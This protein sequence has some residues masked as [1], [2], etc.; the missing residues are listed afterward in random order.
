MD[1]RLRLLV[2]HSSRCPLPGVTAQSGTVIMITNGLPGSGFRPP[3]WAI[4]FGRP[5]GRALLLGVHGAAAAVLVFALSRVSDGLLSAGA[6]IFAILLVP[7]TAGVIL[8]TVLE[9]WLQ[10][11]RTSGTRGRPELSPPFTR[12][13]RSGRRC[14]LCRRGMT[15]T[16]RVWIC[17]ICDQV[18]IGN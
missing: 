14:T 7:L 2:S 3:G 13:A 5:F 18:A 9:A 11:P 8:A 10:A 16:G 15:E 1:T 17:P 4:S 6:F 12:T